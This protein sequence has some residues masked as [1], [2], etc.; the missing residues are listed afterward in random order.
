MHRRYCANQIKVGAGIQIPPNS[1]RLLIKL[2]FG[3]YLEQCVTE[4]EA[5]SFRRWE[6]GKVIGLT[7]LIPNCRETFD[8]PYYVVHR[9][10]L[11]SIMYRRVLDLGI[12]VNLGSRVVDY[13]PQT[14]SINLGNGSTIKADLIVAADG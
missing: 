9:A 14:P 7:K 3:P 4:P 5:I 10:D 13:N 6:N 1:A 11:H 12:K 8:G 2:G